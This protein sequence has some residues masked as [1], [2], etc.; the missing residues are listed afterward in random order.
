MPDI[1]EGA[2]RN[3]AKSGGNG[4]KDE[5]AEYAERSAARRS[6]FYLQPRQKGM[7]NMAKKLF[8]SESVT[9]G[10]PDKICDQISDA[11]LDAIL[12]KDP[13]ARV[14]CETTVTTGLIHVMGEITTNCYVDFQKV[15][16]E[17]V[18]DIGYTRAKFGFEIGRAHV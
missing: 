17:V 12:E 8:T 2:C 15:V 5:G 16:R 14:A 13:M 10:H 9:E 4:S 6:V 11:V 3:T 18:A 7:Q 1:G